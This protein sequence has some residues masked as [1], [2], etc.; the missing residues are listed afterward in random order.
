MNNPRKRKTRHTFMA[1]GKSHPKLSTSNIEE[2]KKKIEKVTK[3]F[4][5]SN[6]IGKIKPMNPDEID[7]V[8]PIF[9]KHK[10]LEGELAM[11]P[12]KKQKT[13]GGK[14]KKKTKKRRRK[15]R[16][17]RRRKKRTRKRSRRR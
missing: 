5:E 17:K 8:A 3:D 11:R 13:K 15:K 10:D 14:R 4:I 12:K 9:G 1:Q 16:T 6:P 7:H 2:I